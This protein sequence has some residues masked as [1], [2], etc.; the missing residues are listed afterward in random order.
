[1]ATCSAKGDVCSRRAMGEAFFGLSASAV[2]VA[3]ASDRP[4]SSLQAPML[5]CFATLNNCEILQ[6]TRLRSLR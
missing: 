5:A 3:V 1:M 4:L 2:I 6:Q